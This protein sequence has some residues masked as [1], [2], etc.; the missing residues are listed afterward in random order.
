MGAAAGAVGGA[1]QLGLVRRTC[2][3][4][5]VE[6]LWQTTK[7]VARGSPAWKAVLRE[8]EQRG[9]ENRG[10]VTTWVCWLLRILAYKQL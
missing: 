2:S 1:V 7:G 6:G 3:C 4:R 5:H 9:E 8:D 10:N